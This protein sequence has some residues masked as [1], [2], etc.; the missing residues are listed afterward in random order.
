[1]KDIEW[2]TGI[3]E[4]EGCI[5]ITGNGGV[6]LG[7]KMNDHDIIHRLHASFGCGSV[8]PAGPKQ[9]LWRCTYALDCKAVLEAM[10]P[11]LGERRSARAAWALNR[12]SEMRWYPRR[13]G[14]NECH[15]GHALLDENVYLYHGK[16]HCRQ[17]R[18]LA[19]LR[20]KE[21]VS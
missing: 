13:A 5:S 14:S 1:M 9:L 16:K 8:H 21:K 20:Q 6:K 4:G 18:R 7:V 3:F 2:A 17:C 15:R 19:K 10:L 11:L 12:I